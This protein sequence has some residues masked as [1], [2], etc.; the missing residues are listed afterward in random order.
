MKSVLELMRLE[1]DGCAY[2]KTTRRMTQVRNALLWY[3]IGTV[4]IK[5]CTKAFQQTYIC[6]KFKIGCCLE[7]ELSYYNN[8]NTYLA[9]NKQ[10]PA[11]N[12]TKLKIK[13]KILLK[14]F[15]VQ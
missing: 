6:N 2:Y 11:K 9:T 14:R 15:Y 1:I 12:V 8:T 7:P 10:F 4:T 3:I 13:W 5:G